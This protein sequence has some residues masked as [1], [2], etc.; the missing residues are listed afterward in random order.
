MRRREFISLVA[1][2]AVAGAEWARAQSSDNGYRV[3][4]FG[5]T[6]DSFSERYGLEFV[7]RLGELGFNEGKSLIIEKRNGTGD[8]RKLPSLAAEL[9]DL[10]CD[11]FFGGGP[12]ANLAALTQ[13]SRGTPIVFVA[14]DFD[15]LATGDVANLARPGGRVTGITAQQSELPAKRLE[16]LRELLPGVNKVAVFTNEET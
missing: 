5:T 4:W 14:V 9:A 16:L 15:P 1:V 11:V 6:A 2:G 10:K 3:G 12:E 13:A 7:R 8:L